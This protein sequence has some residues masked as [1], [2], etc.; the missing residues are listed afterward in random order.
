MIFHAAAA[1]LTVPAAY[2]VLLLLLLLLLRLL[3][4]RLPLP[5]SLLLPGDY[6]SMVNE[7]VGAGGH[8]GSSQRLQLR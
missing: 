2:R 3:L 4:L 8:L 6:G 7:R 5:S 1:G